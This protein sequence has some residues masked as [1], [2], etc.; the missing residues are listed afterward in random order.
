MLSFLEAG[1][2]IE[3]Q[4]ALYLISEIDVLDAYM[5]TGDDVDAFINH[6]VW[7]FPEKLAVQ[8]AVMV[9]PR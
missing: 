5:L 8:D 3:G 7:P 9:K 1:K 6:T 2:L 4:L